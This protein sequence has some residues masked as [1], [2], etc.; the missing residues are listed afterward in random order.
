[1]G[2]VQKY[3]VN[4]DTWYMNVEKFMIIHMRGSAHWDQADLNSLPHNNRFI[5]H[6][7]TKKKKEKKTTS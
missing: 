2:R 1:M 3:L 4:N 5:N 6:K 7:N